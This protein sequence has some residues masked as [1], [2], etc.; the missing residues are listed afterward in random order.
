MR[1][2]VVEDEITSRILL[3]TYLEEYGD[4]DTAR[5]FGDAI[6]AFRAALSSNR[7]YNLVCLDIRLPGV[8][9]HGILKAIRQIEKEEMIDYLDAVTVVMTTALSDT[10]NI[11]KAY[12]EYCDGYLH[13]PVTRRNLDG[14]IKRAGLSE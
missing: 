4:C 14:F 12:Y 13:K 11:T 5:H 6:A 9:G 10:E 1:S 2:L 7:R 3:E 8:S